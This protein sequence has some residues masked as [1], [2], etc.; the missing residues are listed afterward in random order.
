VT[1]TKPTALASLETVKAWLNLPG[2]DTTADFR[3]AIAMNAATGS[4]ET[5]TGAIFVQRAVSAVLD[6]TGKWAMA[7][8][9]KPI[10]GAL[11]S[12]TIDGI[13][14][15]P[16]TYVLDPATGII[17]FT[18]ALGSVFTYGTGGFTRGTQNVIVGA[19]A[20]YDVQDGP[21]LPSEIYLAGLNLAKA[22]Y[23]EL[24]S[25]TIIATTVSLGPSTL[26]VKAAGWPPTVKRDVDLWLSYQV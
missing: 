12:F 25:N 1:A 23:D 7:L 13:A 8:P 2:L 24:A 10:V 16:T 4:I 9:W 6:G 19:M 17:R 21:S 18:G 3:L 20:G 11:T 22:T 26:V 5:Y 14:V 15:D